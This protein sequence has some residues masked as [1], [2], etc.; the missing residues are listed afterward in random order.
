MPALLRSFGLQ[1]VIPAAE[2]VLH[3]Y[4]ANPKSHTAMSQLALTSRLDGLRSRCRTLALWIYFKAR[5]ICGVG[6]LVVCHTEKIISKK[7]AH[8]DNDSG[9]GYTQCKGC[10]MRTS[11]CTIV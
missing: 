2:A 6:G 9:A 4:L 8:K 10:K 11:V 5:R 1:L 3:H 7:T